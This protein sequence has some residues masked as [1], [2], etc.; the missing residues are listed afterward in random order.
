M[1]RETPLAQFTANVYPQ[2]AYQPF[3]EFAWRPFAEVAVRALGQQKA[4]HPFGLGL[5]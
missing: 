5:I 4:Q 2:F 1:R 3:D